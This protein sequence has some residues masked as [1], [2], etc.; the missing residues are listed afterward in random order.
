VI[1]PLPQFREKL[2][3]E[4]SAPVLVT[5]VRQMSHKLQSFDSKIENQFIMQETLSVF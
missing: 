3:V 1:G 2:H 5:Q 4:S